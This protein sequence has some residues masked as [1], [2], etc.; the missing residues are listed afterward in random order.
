M[1]SWDMSSVAT[2]STALTA[3]LSD[4]HPVWPA[5]NRPSPTY[6]GKHKQEN[7]M[8]EAVSVLSHVPDSLTQGLSS[9]SHGSKTTSS[10]AVPAKK[11]TPTSK[12]SAQARFDPA[13][14]AITANFDRI[15]T[16]GK[17]QGDSRLGT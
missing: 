7:S 2:S 9:V 3:Q 6:P 12:A 8:P 15:S 5:P 14:F 11:Q 13:R 4:S 17:Y 1:L 16:S 10:A